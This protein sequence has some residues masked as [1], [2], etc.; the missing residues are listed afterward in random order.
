[1]PFLFKEQLKKYLKIFQKPID[2]LVCVCYNV[3]TINEEVFKM[4]KIL[5]YLCAS[6][7]AIGFFVLLGS[8][9]AIEQNTMSVSTSV[10][11]C[12]IG[13]AVMCIS[14]AALKFFDNEEE[15]K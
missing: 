14:A 5:E 12:L 7:C 9:G 4:K 2:I 10:V 11:W 15:K 8:V 3:I 13:L 6:M 1:M